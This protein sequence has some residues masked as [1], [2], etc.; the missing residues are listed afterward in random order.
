MNT[1]RLHAVMLVNGDNREKLAEDMGIHAST[2]Y[3][4]M[5]GIESKWGRDF[6]VS[7]VKF[8]I[9]RYKMSPEEVMS[10]FFN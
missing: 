1:D 6:T 3:A 9:D 2:L 7:E 8:I 10:I 4:K 5:R